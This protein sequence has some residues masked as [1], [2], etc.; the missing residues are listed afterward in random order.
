M[1][2]AE[3]LLGIRARRVGV[4]ADVARGARD[5]LAGLSAVVLEPEVSCAF[6]LIAGA[7]TTAEILL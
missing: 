4:D 1:V 3:F 2:G 5:R 6:E 7:A